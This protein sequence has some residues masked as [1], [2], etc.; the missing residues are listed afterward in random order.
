METEEQ[1]LSAIRSGDTSAFR[2]LYER[3]SRYAM[4]IGL[5]YIPERDEANDVLQDSFVKI[6]TSIQ[7]FD[8]QGEGSLR[9]WIRRIVVNQAIDHI[10]QRER[11]S[12]VS[13]I[14]DEVVD[15]DIDIEE[16]PSEILARMVGQLPTNY[17]LV[18]NLYVFER[19]THSE[20]AQLLG[21]KEKTSSSLFYRAKITL[22]KLINDYLNG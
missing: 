22:K 15:E 14:P 12:F 11:V 18:L 4:A 20:I 3:Y 13:I 17:R 1:L 8:Y 7:R 2:R 9:N 5:R 21:I 10:H 19:L 16:I 6:L